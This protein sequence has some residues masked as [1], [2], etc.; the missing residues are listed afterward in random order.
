MREQ[1]LKLTD[2][3]PGNATGEPR[4]GFISVG[5]LTINLSPLSRGNPQRPIEGNLRQRVIRRLGISAIVLLALATP[6]GTLLT[7]NYVGGELFQKA[8]EVQIYFRGSSVP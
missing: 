3:H 8:M 1:L 5:R 7:L 6:V 2:E 4:T